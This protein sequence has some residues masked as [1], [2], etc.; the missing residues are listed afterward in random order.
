[1]IS[2]L[3]GVRSER[4][5]LPDV[6]HN[7]DADTNTIRSGPICSIQGTIMFEDPRHCLQPFPS[8]ESHNTAQEICHVLVVLIAFSTSVALPM[9]VLG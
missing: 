5:L 4:V 2:L 7:R 9:A 1:M 6:G 3:G 8:Q